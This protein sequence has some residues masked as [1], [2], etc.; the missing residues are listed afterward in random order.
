MEKTKSG[1]TKNYRCPYCKHPTYSVYNLNMHIASKHPGKAT[2]DPKDKEKMKVKP[3]DKEPE[4]VGSD[5]QTDY[6][7][8][9][10]EEDKSEPEIVQPTKEKD[11]DDLYGS[12]DDDNDDDEDDP[13]A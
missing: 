5:V 11:A 1:R 2:I 10:E 9:E 8:A 3:G 13:Y 7:P 6:D 4:K 12:G